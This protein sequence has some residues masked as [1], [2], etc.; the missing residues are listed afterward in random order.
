[1]KSG[2]RKAK[3]VGIGETALAE[4]DTVDL[5]T[6]QKKSLSAEKNNATI[7]KVAKEEIVH[8]SIQKTTEEVQGSFQEFCKNP[9][10]LFDHFLDRD[11]TQVGY[12]GWW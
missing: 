3:V 9:N 5:N 10:C 12:R 8:I 11:Q 6:H 2:I 1:M 7:K 4:I